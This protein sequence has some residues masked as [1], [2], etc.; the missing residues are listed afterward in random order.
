MLEEPDADHFQVAIRYDDSTAAAPDV[1][2]E[3]WL[4]PPGNTYETTDIWI[5]TPL[6]GYA[7]PP[8]SDAAHYRYSVQSDLRGGTVPVGNGDD[9][10]VGQVNR[11]CSCGAAR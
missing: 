9:P 10:A 2:L 6:N 11:L 4:Q 3:S 7:S 5:D 8:D 1:G